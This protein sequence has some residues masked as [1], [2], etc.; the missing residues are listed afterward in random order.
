MLLNTIVITFSD[1]KQSLIFLRQSDHYKCLYYLK[2]EIIFLLLQI[3]QVKT[4]GKMYRR[5]VE[6]MARGPL[7]EF[8]IFQFMGTHNN[9]YYIEFCKVF[10]FVRHVMFC[11]CPNVNSH[12]ALTV[13]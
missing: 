5:V 10:I 2:S 9:N 3:E 4:G 13:V 11:L 8:I 1:A 12:M 7:N 6:R